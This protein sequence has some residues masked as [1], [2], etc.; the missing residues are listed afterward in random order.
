LILFKSSVF[1]WGFKLWPELSRKSWHVMGPP[2]A[3]YS[4]FSSSFL[5]FIRLSYI[6][7]SHIR[8]HIFVSLLKEYQT[9]ASVKAARGTARRFHGIRC[10]PVSNTPVSTFAPTALR[11]RLRR[12][13]RPAVGM[14]RGK[15]ESARKRRK[16]GRARGG[17]TGRRIAGR[18]ADTGP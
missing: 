3:E 2:R 18:R 11:Q 5:I 15:G 4:S 13:R 17:K 10:L 7:L 12:I 8:L 16:P 9:G 6:R 14:L 1:L